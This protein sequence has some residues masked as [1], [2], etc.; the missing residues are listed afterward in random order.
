MLSA[1]FRKRGQSGGSENNFY[2]L[3]QKYYIPADRYERNYRPCPCIMAAF[4]SWNRSFNRPD[5]L[6]DLSTQ[7]I[8][9]P[10]S[11]EVS[12]LVVKSVT[13]S[14]KQRWTSFEYI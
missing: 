10:S 6:S 14:S 4:C 8:T 7:R 1:V 11:R 9:H 5:A 2:F 13:Q 3:C 12:D